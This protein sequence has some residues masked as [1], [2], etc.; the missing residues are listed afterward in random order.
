MVYAN[1]PRRLSRDISLPRA[2]HT[3]AGLA[4]ITREAMA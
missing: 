2:A 3:G 4:S 1:V